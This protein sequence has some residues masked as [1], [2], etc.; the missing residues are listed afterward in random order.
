MKI[1]MITSTLVNNI[2]ISFMN[3]LKR[4]GDKNSPDIIFPVDEFFIDFINY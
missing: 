2:G 4:V 1:N 3:I